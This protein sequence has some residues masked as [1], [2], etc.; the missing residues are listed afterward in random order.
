MMEI[1]AGCSFRK[2][3]SYL[4]RFS[5]IRP[6]AVLLTLLSLGIA[7]AKELHP[8]VIGQDD[9][10]AIRA[11]GS[12]WDAIG[13]VNVSGYRTISKCSGILIGPTA[14][15]TAAHCLMDTR[16]MAPVPPD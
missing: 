6:I 7:G 10:I 3:L 9:R 4:Q 2:R 1:P 14:V 11:D 16:K 13:H 12:P 5:L 8:G 15:L